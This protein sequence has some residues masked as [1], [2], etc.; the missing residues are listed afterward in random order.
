E[1]LLV[2]TDAPYL[3]PHPYRGKRNEPARVTLVAEQIAELKG[4]SYEEVCEQTTKN[5]EK[6]FNL[7]S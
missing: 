2:E 5:P 3:S 6:L 7:N 4:L 1:R